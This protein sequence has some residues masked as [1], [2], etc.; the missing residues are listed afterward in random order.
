MTINFAPNPDTD[1]MFVKIY[2]QTGDALDACI[3]AGYMTY[4]YEARAV[5]D[6]LLD[7][8]DIALAIK[9][10]Q[11]QNRTRAPIEITRDSIVSDL[12]NI[13]AS[14]FI[15]K[16]YGHAISAK[17]TQ[18][19]LLGFVQENVQVTHRM[20]VKQMTDEQIL[21]L[22]ALK[23]KQ[24]EGEFTEVEEEKQPIGLGKPDDKT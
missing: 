23:S 3:R 14:A 7:R 24:I 20:D 9:M 19:T 16:E 18:A 1:E 10:G 4:G 13:H 5:A 17:K 15:E 12:E 22:I 11:A 6:Y 8:P 21:K 2:L